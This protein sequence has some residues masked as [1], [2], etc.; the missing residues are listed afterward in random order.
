LPPYFL[1]LYYTS[2]QVIQHGDRLY[3]NVYFIEAIVN[4]FDIQKDDKNTHKRF[5]I[6]WV[7]G[8]YKV[9]NQA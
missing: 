3:S 5:A 7:E 8:A 9:Y 6:F 4:E 2:G 1:V